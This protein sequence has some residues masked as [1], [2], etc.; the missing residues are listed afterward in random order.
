MK[1]SVLLL[2]AL[3]F[4]VNISSYAQTVDEN[5]DNYFENTGGADVENESALV[6][7]EPE[8]LYLPI[9]VEA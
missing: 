3:I 1:N 5:I 6:V 2:V 4:S 9:T 8:E 7:V